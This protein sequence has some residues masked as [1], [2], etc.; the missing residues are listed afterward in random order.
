MCILPGIWEYL[1]NIGMITALTVLIL[2]NAD[3][4]QKA[5][6]ALL[7]DKVAKGKGIRRGAGAQLTWPEAVVGEGLT[8]MTNLLL[9]KL[10]EG[11][12]LLQ[13]MWI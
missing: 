12:I 3:L 4:F 11:Q 8:R 6:I 5:L 2:K 13:V 10:F 7:T 9:T 1:F